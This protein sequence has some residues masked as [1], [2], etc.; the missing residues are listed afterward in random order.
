M[1][2]FFVLL[3]LLSHI[4]QAQVSNKDLK[5]NGIYLS[6]KDYLNGKL[7]YGFNK[8]KGVKF[9]DIKKL[10][11]SIKETDTTFKFYFDEIWGYRKDGID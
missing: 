3:L 4:L 10:S 5:D 1:K 7:S 6:D 8:D 2:T 11:I 9:K